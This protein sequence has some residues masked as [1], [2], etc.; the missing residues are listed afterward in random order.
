MVVRVGTVSEYATED[1]AKAVSKAGR[2]RR[3]TY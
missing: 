1:N 3:I 2:R